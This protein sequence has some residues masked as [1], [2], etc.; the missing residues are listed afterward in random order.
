ME[1][2]AYN[3]AEARGQQQKKPTSVFKALLPR[4]HK[5]SR[6]P[7]AVASPTKSENTRPA[8]AALSPTKSGN[9][10]LATQE[11]TKD[12]PM[13]P[14]SIPNANIPVAEA[15]H[16]RDRNRSSPRK[17]IDVYDDTKNKQTGVENKPVTVGNDKRKIQKQQSP[18]KEDEVKAKKSKSSTTLSAM[19]GKSKSSRS[20]KSEG[21]K[22]Q[23]AKVKDKENCTPPNSSNGPPPPIWAQF[24]S[25]PMMEVMSTQKVPLNDR[26]DDDRRNVNHEV[27]RYT[28]R[29][30]SPSKG[31][32]FYDEQPTLSRRA[33]PKPRPKSTYLPSSLSS[34]SFTETISVLRKVSQRHKKTDVGRFQEQMGTEGTSSRRSSTD[35]RKVSN[36]SSDSGLT[37]AKRGSR[38]Q[39]AVAALNGK[40][41]EPEVGAKPQ[42]PSDPRAFDNAFEAVL[43]R[44]A[45]L[46]PTYCPNISRNRGILNRTYGRR[47]GRLTLISKQSSSKRTT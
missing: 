24:A 45:M 15:T 38:V 5:N 3:A 6:Y 25:T 10:W 31:R 8:Y 44:T 43:V 7:D 41:K 26:W 37:M 23:Q 46:K 29:E 47:C 30:Y 13:L 16:N 19:F 40:A 35:S 42:V 4:S 36:D 17:P 34:N 39:A 18:A 27:E 20:L 1:P 11:P 32:N 21:E 33:E 12:L 22:H 14:M 28:P 9:I 2:F